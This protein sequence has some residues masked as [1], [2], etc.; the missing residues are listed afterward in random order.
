MSLHM[1]LSLCQR[2]KKNY[3]FLQVPIQLTMQTLLALYSYISQW[4]FS[5]RRHATLELAMLV[6]RSIGPLVRPWSSQ[7]VSVFTLFRFCPPVRHWGGE[8]IWPCFSFSSVC[9]HILAIRQSLNQLRR[10][11]INT[12]N[13]KSGVQTIF[14]VLEMSIFLTNER[15]SFEWFRVD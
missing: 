3:E 7:K 12:I 6:H 1:L 10:K 2:N 9:L 13:M 4:A 15:I 5:H 8:C 14:L 11:S